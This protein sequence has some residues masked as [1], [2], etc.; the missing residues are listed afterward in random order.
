MTDPSIWHFLIVYDVETGVPAVEDFGI[1]DEAACR[2]YES[3][4]RAHRFDPR[5][6]VVLLGAD[7]LDTIKQTDSACFT[8][9]VER[10]LEALV[11]RAIRRRAAA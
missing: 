4:G 7:A 11:D 3:R 9:S 8:R 1:D 2:A 10:R 6:E 5:G